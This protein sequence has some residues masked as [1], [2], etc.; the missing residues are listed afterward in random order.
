[1]MNKN[2]KG[3]YYKY[4]KKKFFNKEGYQTEYLERSQRIFIKGR[5]IYIKRDLFASDGLS[6]REKGNKI[7][8]WQC[9]LNKKNVA[10]ARK[11]FA[12]FSFPKCA[13]RWII[14]WI[15]RAKEPIIIKLK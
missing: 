6:I 3:D 11:E 2:K 9:K 5:S 12:K 10:A 1:M 4:K 13:E 14:V 15:P 8:F 7:I